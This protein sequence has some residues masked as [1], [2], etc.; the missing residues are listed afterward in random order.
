MDEKKLDKVTL[1]LSELLP[2]L[3]QK[4]IKPFEQF[5]KSNISLMQFYVIFTLEEKGELTMTQLSNE[6]LISKQQMTPLTDK[7]IDAGFAERKY[8]P[9]DRRMVKI[10]LTSQGQEFLQKQRTGIFSML[11]EKLENLGAGDLDLLY[12]SFT[13]IKKIINKL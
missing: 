3:Q 10:R 2:L 5:A 1:E 4:L 8:D 7:I 6:L 11:K 12:L 13:D 9:A